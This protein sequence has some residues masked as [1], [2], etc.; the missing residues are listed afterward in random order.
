MRLDEATATR[1]GMVLGTL[2]LSEAQRRYYLAIEARP[3]GAGGAAAVARA[4]GAGESTVREG[5]R[6]LEGDREAVRARLEGGRSRRAGGGRKAAEE[7]HPGLQRLVLGI[8]DEATYGDPERDVAYSAK[9]VRNVAEEA[10]AIMSAEE[11]REVGVSHETVRLVL[12]GAGYSP[13]GNKKC[14]QVGEPS[15]DRDAQFRHIASRIDYYLSAGAP[16]ISVDTK[17]KELLGDYVAAGEEWTPPAT[18]VCVKDHDYLDKLLGKAIPYGVYDVGRNEGFVNVGNSADTAQFA[19][20][21]IQRWWDEVGRYEYPGADRLLIL[22]DGGGSNGYRC[23]LWRLSLQLFADRNRIQVEVCHY[24]AGNSKFNK[25]ERR[26][27]SQISIQWRGQPLTSLE[28]VRNLIASTTTRTGLVVRATIDRTVYQ[29]G[30]RV[31]DAVMDALSIVRH[32]FRGEW[33]YLVRVRASLDLG[34]A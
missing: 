25:I 12:R 4:A 16:V 6:D 20:E 28:T 23:R 1:I 26:L 27:F 13:K 17:K 7:E 31:P 22:C 24:P 9:S 33:N 3:L 34:A 19:L 5:M 11:G 18:Y 10:S 8:V 30:I 29:R 2:G 15:P 21:S 14:L 32:D